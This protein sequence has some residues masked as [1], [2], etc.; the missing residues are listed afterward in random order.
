VLPQAAIVIDTFH[1]QSMA[2][3]ELNRIL[4]RLRVG[5]ALTK[6]R[7]LVSKMRSKEVKRTR[8]LLD[9]RRGNLSKAEAA[10]LL[11][12]RQEFPVLDTAYKLKEGFLNVWLAEDRR[13]AEKRYD[14]WAR[15]V[16]KTMPHAFKKIR[17][18][19]KGRR[20]EIFNYFDYDRETNAVTEARNNSVKT[21]QRVGRGYRFPVVRTKLLYSDTITGHVSVRRRRKRKAQRAPRPVNPNS[22][23]ERLKGA[24]EGR[25]ASVFK[26][27][28]VNADWLRR[29]DHL[30]KD[31]RFVRAGDD[32]AK[33]RVGGKR[34]SDATHPLFAKCRIS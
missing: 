29:F 1:V 33:L 13:Q 9:K 23:V 5:V 31:L 19:V 3:R 30:K 14:A 8:F 27:P 16:E 21:L 28:P 17:V 22:N 24:Y 6:E 12:W 11:K 18:N 20:A 2:N 4:S 7:R 10:E 15:R 34:V 25:L 26:A 32:P